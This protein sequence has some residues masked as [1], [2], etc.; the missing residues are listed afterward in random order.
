MRKKAG[1][2]QNDKIEVEQPNIICEYGKYSSYTNIDTINILWEYIDIEDYYV[3]NGIVKESSTGAILAAMGTNYNIDQYYN[4]TFENG[5]KI[6]VKNIDIKADEHTDNKNCYT[7]HDSTL[8][9]IWV[10]NDFDYLE[11][12]ISKHTEFGAI[13]EIKEM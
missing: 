4:L 6:F 2:P 5:T 13:T 1:N 3:D 11:A 12:G 8:V 10:T 9:E 7:T